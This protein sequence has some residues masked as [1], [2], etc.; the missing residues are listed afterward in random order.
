MAGGDPDRIKMPSRKTWHFCAFLDYSVGLFLRKDCLSAVTVSE[1]SLI[2]VKSQ[3]A[4]KFASQLSNWGK[5]SEK[6]T[7]AA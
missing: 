3:S 5:K 6:Y 2:S 1:M 4:A 7:K